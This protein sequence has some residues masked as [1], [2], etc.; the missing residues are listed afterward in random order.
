MNKVLL[1]ILIIIALAVLVF[2]PSVMIFTGR[3]E[4]PAIY[5]YPTEDSPVKVRLEINGKMTKSVP[6]YGEEWQVFAA[7][8]GIIDS[9]YDYLFY[10]AKLR[11]L[12]LP[13]EGWVVKYSDLIS[14]FDTNLPKMGLNEKEKQQFEEYWLGKL[15]ESAY[16]EIKLFD[17]A[18]LR[19]NMNLL[20][21]PQPDTVIRLEFYFKP[22]KEK[23][24]LPE[25][26]IATPERIGFTVVEWGGMIG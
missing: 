26:S 16:Y 23:V 15:P 19:E 1:L 3:F 8:S 14:W 11:R 7:K 10:E 20:I 21:S 9:K 24:S 22:L 17:E 5:L 2:I 12:E 18:F 25:P 4:K 6:D 13:K